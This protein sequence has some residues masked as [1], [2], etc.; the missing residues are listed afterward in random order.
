M[1]A[2][3]CSVVTGFNLA[4]E[5]IQQT[6]WV[7]ILLP[8]NNLSIYRQRREIILTFSQVMTER[9]IPWSCIFTVAEIWGPSEKQDGVTANSL[10]SGVTPWNPSICKMLDRLSNTTTQHSSKAYGIQSRRPVTLNGLSG[11]LGKVNEAL[12]AQC[13]PKVRRRT[14][15]EWWGSCQDEGHL[16]NMAQSTENLRFIEFCSYFPHFINK[17]IEL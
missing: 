15:P 14:D 13:L 10:V 2:E 6:D 17:E 12:W 16:C 8:K 11:H 9:K 7:G 1:T 5:S 3:S 4:A